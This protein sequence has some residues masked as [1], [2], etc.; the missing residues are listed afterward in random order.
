MK[1]SSTFSPFPLSF[2]LVCSQSAVRKDQR[3]ST[4]AASIP[5]I[6][7][8]TP[9]PYLELSIASISI[10]MAFGDPEKVAATSNSPSLSP[11]DISPAHAGYQDENYELYK[12]GKEVDYDPAEVKRVLRKVDLRI[13]PIL[14][15]TYML[16]YLDKNSLNFASVYG[17]Q[18]GTHLHGQDY[19]WLGELLGSDGCMMN[20]AN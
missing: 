3:L 16:Q 8:S 1:L 4:E 11:D 5:C 20:R 13:I 6:L 17:L 12:N 10:K 14:F 7:C 15:V 18:K 2:L 9:G 19:S